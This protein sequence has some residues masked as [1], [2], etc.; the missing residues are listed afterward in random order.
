LKLLA[1]VG[2]PRRKGNTN[3]LV[4]K[5]LKKAEELGAETEKLVL[6]KYR[7]K[8][9]LGHE[10]CS[11]LGSCSIKDDT[12]WILD[13]LCCADG[14]I[15]ATP[16]YYFNVT[17]Q[18]KAFIDRNYFL[19]EHNKKAKA[20]AVGVIVAGSEGVEDTLNTIKLYVNDTFSII[21]DQIL[22]VTAYASKPGDIKQN[23]LS[24]KEAENLGQTIVKILKS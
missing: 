21:N 5:A 16:V 3:Y 20:K 18:M 17:A 15:L 11:T 2:S 14:V 12:S 6:S 9:C 10:N 22:I 24:V 23:L 19:Y 8:P 4:D 13:K 7:V 1:I